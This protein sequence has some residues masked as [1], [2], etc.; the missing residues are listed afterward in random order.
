MCV[1]IVSIGQS[2]RNEITALF[3]CLSCKI[4][5]V[6]GALDGTLIT[7]LAPDNENMVDYYNRKQRYSINT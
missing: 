3:C 6:V 2:T 4:Q 1:R 5:I 7:I